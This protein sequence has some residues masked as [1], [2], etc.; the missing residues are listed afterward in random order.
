VRKI[1]VVHMDGTSLMPCSPAKARKLIKKGGA[2]KRWTKTGIF[3]I[4]LTTPTGK[5]TQ[6]MALGIDPGAH[7]DGIA[8]ATK[9]QMQFSGML[10]VKNRIKE[11]METRRNMRRARRFRKTRRRPKRFSNRRRPEG[12]LPPSIKAKVDMRIQFL[13]HLFTIY[14]ITQIAVEDMRIDGNKLK[15]V[16]GREYFTWTMENKRKLYQFLEGKGALRLFD[17]KETAKARETLGLEKTDKKGEHSFYSQAVD[18]F[19]LCW[20][21]IRTKRTEVP[22]FAVWRR[23]DVP[24]RQLHRLEPEKGGIRKPYG[25][26]VACGFRKN[27]VVWHKGSLYRTGG[28]T[29]GKLSLHSFDFANKRVTQHA[30]PAKCRK[31]FH[32]SWFYKWVI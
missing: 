21:V 13:S 31:V 23:P 14:P 1:P 29:K 9:E 4:Q 20:L 30:D 24:R 32:Q 8:I 27:T 15:G 5:R 16:K 2:V 6:E 10:V 17:A 18:G 19:A 11:K 22:L 28:T 3:Y 12:W 26:S 25:G 7:Y